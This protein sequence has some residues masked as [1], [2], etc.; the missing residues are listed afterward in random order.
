LS[1]IES[2]IGVPAPRGSRR[3]IA[4]ESHPKP[5]AHAHLHE[6]QAGIG[7]VIAASGIGFSSKLQRKKE[8]RP[9]HHE[10]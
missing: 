5:L 3:A 9:N 1:E 4:S 7:E 6:S 8:S 10:I 2:G